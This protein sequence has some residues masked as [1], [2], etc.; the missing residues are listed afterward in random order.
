M[1]RLTSALEKSPGDPEP[2]RPTSC[3]FAGNPSGLYI[4]QPKH[5]ELPKSRKEDFEQVIAISFARL[6][7]VPAQRVQP[8]QATQ[9]CP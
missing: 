7:T 6:D 3:I 9:E 4:A 8:M 5:E 1:K 2:P